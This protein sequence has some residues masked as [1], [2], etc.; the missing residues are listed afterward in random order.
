M[1]DGWKEKHGKGG[2]G[3]REAVER[4]RR[5]ETRRDSAFGKDGEKKKKTTQ[6]WRN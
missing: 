6:D 1:D 2:S 4:R 3:T 5:R